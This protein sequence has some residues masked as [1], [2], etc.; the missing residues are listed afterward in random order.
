[1]MAEKKAQEPRYYVQSDTIRGEG[2][3]HYII[4]RHL[5]HRTVTPP[6]RDKKRTEKTCAAMNESEASSL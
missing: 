6:S 3:H 1:M 2:R 4:D 5:N